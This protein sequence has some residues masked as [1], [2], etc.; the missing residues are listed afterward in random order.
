MWLLLNLLS[1]SSRFRCGCIKSSSAFCFEAWT[2]VVNWESYA[3]T[4]PKDAIA[5]KNSSNQQQRSSRQSTFSRVGSIRG[6]DHYKCVTSQQRDPVIWQRP[7]LCHCTEPGICRCLPLCHWTSHCTIPLWSDIRHPYPAAKR[8][9]VGIPNEPK[10]RWLLSSV[11][12]SYL[13]D[14]HHERKQLF[15]LVVVLPGPI[16]WDFPG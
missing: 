7:P 13:L 14:Q 4:K 1:S 6:S 3:I 2:G 11:Q 12:I 16:S 9:K 8:N 10:V 5:P 15:L